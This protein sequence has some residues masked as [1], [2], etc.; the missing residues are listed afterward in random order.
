MKLYISRSCHGTSIS[1][2]GKGK[3]LHTS[4]YGQRVFTPTELQTAPVRDPYDETNKDTIKNLQRQL[5]NLQVYTTKKSKGNI[6]F[7]S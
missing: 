3:M 1:T 2:L 6:K 4:N 5:T 7:K